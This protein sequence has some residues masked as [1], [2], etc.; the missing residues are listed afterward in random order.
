MFYHRTCYETLVQWKRSS[1]RKPLILRGARQVG[2][3]SLIDEF[4]RKEFKEIVT[5]NFEEDPSWK[6]LFEKDFDTGRIINLIEV[7]TRRKIVPSNTLIFFDEI[8]QCPRAI[9]ALRYFYEKAKQ[10]YL[11]AAGS[12]LEFALEEISFPVGRVDSLYIYPFS[13]EEFLLAT[14]RKLLLPLIPRFEGFKNPPALPELMI[15]KQLEEAFQEYLVVGGM[16]ES[17]TKFNETGSYLEVF[18]V[19]QSLV[20]SFIDDTRKYAKGDRQLENIAAIL[21]RIPRFVGQE[22]TYTTLG[23][24]ENHQRTKRSLELLNRAMV[25]TAVHSASPAGNSLSSSFSEKHFKS[26]FID[27]GLMS[28]I[29]GLEV[30]PQVEQQE[31]NPPSQGPQYEQFVGQELLCQQRSLGIQE[32]NL[33]CWIRPQRTAKAEVDYLIHFQG[34]TIPI[35]VKSGAIGKMKSLQLLLHEYPNIPYGVVLSNT[36]TVEKNGKIIKLPIY[37]RMLL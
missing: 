14:N 15:L 35:E 25:I 36:R 34:Q 19:Q 4:A 23:D 5:L 28:K 26:L 8:Q 29:L 20:G 16:P 13:F 30:L 21:Q 2:K 6:S 33:F 7:K 37:T 12:L 9:T 10:Y 27:V 3:S 18:K 11:V 24:G 31:K 17:I 1:S 32:R 22:V